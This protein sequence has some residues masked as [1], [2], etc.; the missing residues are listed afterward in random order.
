M[1]HKLVQSG[2][3]AKLFEHLC[4]RNIDLEESSQ[5]KGFLTVRFF[6]LQVHLYF[7]VGQKL[8]QDIYVSLL[9]LDSCGEFHHVVVIVKWF[10][11]EVII[12]FVV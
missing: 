5:L 4:I 10:E 6:P 8:D 2:D 1:V 3:L 12:A 9:V 7:I 11:S